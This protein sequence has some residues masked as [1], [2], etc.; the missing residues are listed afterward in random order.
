MFFE[1]FL[2][3]QKAK[4]PEIVPRKM[5]INSFQLRL[6]FPTTVPSIE[7]SEPNRNVRKGELFDN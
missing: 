6:S 1:I 7:L 2:A 4:E 5:K 3:Q